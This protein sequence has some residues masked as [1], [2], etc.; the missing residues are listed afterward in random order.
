V[1]SGL[2]GY[3]FR[4]RCL[5]NLGKRLVGIKVK[6]LFFFLPCKKKSDNV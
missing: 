5:H 4:T 1:N 2:D 6:R 3:F